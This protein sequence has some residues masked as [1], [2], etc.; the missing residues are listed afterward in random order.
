VINRTL[1][2]PQKFT[3]RDKEYEFPVNVNENDQD[4]FREVNQRLTERKN[5][6]KKTES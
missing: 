5:T 1:N 4:A 6:I 2:Q 3:L